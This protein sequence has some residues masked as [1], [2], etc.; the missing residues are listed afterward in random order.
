Q[1]QPR[2]NDVECPKNLILFLNIN[3]ANLSLYCSN[4]FARFSVSRVES[5]NSKANDFIFFSSIS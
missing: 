2:L 4:I 5:G 1:Q 3:I